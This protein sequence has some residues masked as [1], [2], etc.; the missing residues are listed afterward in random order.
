MP[1]SYE[2]S[3]ACLANV[4]WISYWTTEARHFAENLPEA[5]L[6]PSPEGELASQVSFIKQEL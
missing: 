1:H 4:C 2:V 6:S 3:A 5:N